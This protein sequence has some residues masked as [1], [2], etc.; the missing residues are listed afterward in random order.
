MKEMEES[1]RKMEN[2]NQIKYLE[3]KKNIVE[4]HN[5]ELAKYR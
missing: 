2:E 1:Y 3:E 4:K 5:R